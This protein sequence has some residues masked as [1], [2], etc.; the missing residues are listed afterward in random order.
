MQDIRQAL[1][2]LPVNPPDEV[3]ALRFIDAAKRRL[4][5]LKKES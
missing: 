2:D 1:A 5:D 3:R 4:D